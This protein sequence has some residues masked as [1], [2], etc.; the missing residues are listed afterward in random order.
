MLHF[1]TVEPNTLELLRRLDVSKY[2]TD[3]IAT[4]SIW[5]ETLDANAKT[6]EALPEVGKTFT[7]A[8]TS[9]VK[10]SLNMKLWLLYDCPWVLCNGYEEGRAY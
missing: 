8:L 1:E 5:L 4:R 2:G 9:P 7:V 10:F 6:L 3:I